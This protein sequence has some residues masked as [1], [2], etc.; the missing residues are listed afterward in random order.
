M[1]FRPLR[2]IGA[3][4]RRPAEPTGM[5]NKGYDAK[6]GD[7]TNTGNGP[8]TARDRMGLLL[9][10]SIA[11]VLLESMFPGW[12]SLP[13]WIHTVNPRRALCSKAGRMSKA[14]DGM[15]SGVLVAI[16]L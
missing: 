13:H 6:L 16:G 4:I 12:R 3:Q 14:I 8:R 1:S 5:I 11:V 10:G 9:L 7:R 15:Q 2:E